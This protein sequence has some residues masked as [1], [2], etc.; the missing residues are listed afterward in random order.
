MPALGAHLAVDFCKLFLK[1]RDALLYYTAVSLYLGF[2]HAAAGT[3]SSPLSF[4]VGPHTGKSWKHVVVLCQFH[5]HLC[6][7]GLG[8][9]C[10]DFQYETGSVYYYAVLEKTLYI[11]LLH[12]GEFVIED[13]V[14]YAIGF[15]VFPDFL[16]FAATDIGGA[17]GTVNLLYKGFVAC[18][19]GCFREETEFVEVFTNSVFVVILLDDSDE[20]RFFGEYLRLF[21]STP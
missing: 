16:Y 7:G 1:T 18:D 21:Q 14:T 3:S 13:A 5:L 6:V 10:E 15:A 4:E 2:A 19:T 20:D 8:S 11:A 12:S 9:L 17:V